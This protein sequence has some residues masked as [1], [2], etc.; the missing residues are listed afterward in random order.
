MGLPTKAEYRD[1]GMKDDNGEPVLEGSIIIAD[2]Y[3]ADESQHYC[4]VFY[5]G[6]FGSCA[7]GDFEPISRYK[8]IIVKGHVEEFR[9]LYENNTYWD[10]PDG[11]GG[12][13]GNLGEALK[14]PVL[15]DYGTW[16][17]LMPVVK[18]IC[19]MDYKLTNGDEP[20]TIGHGLTR[21][22][23]NEALSAVVKFVNQYNKFK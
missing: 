7:Y 22:D 13:S 19:K 14:E 15:K 18:K 10:G 11:E 17:E 5:E 21:V 20:G 6:Q 9:E 1:S 23:I 4:V 12:Y 8:S 2:G 3:G 16:N